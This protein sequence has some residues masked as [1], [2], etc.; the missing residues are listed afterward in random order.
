MGI[1]TL[2]G[3]ATLFE[4]DTPQY[5]YCEKDE[6]DNSQ[7]PSFSF[8]LWTS[9]SIQFDPQGTSLLSQEHTLRPTHIHAPSPIQT[10]FLKWTHM[11][12][13][14]TANTWL[15]LK[16]SCLD[17]G[18]RTRARKCSFPIINGHTNTRA[19]ATAERDRLNL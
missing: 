6:S 2:D 14:M 13:L 4:R 5:L 15:P 18:E 10:K 19:V 16:Q 17:A 1:H 11:Q 7:V 12:P 3:E 9:Q 8:S